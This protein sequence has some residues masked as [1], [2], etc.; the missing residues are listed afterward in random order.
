MRL[1]RLF[2]RDLAKECSEWVKDNL[3]S[4]DQAEKICNRY[5]VNYKDVSGQTYGYSVLIGL[6]YLFIGLAVITLLSANWDDI[7]RAA[8]MLGILSL[9][10][11]INLLAL[12]KIN[13]GKS[14][15]AIGLFFLGGLIYGA[16]IML[17]A[18]IFHIEEH[19]PNG[20]LWWAIGVLPLALL[21][22]SSLLFSLTMGLSFIW[23]FVE[24]NLNY[25]PI[26]F[27]VFL[28]ALGWH[29]FKIKQ[30][31]VLFLSFIFGIGLWLE[32]TM[33]WFLNGGNG[34]YV[35]AEN[36]IFGIGLFISFHGASKWLVSQKNNIL[37]DYGTILGIWILRL[38]IILLLLLSFE[39]LWK[40][41][42]QANWESLELT[43]ALAIS[44]ST[45]GIYLSYA[46]NKQFYSTLFFALIFILETFLVIE[47]KD[48]FYA[49]YFQ[50]ATNIVLVVT[51]IW[52]IV[53][54][55]KDRA[56]H[57]FFLGVSTILLTGFF[58][59]M[60]LVGDYIGA[61]ILFMVFSVILL[62]AARF[63]KSHQQSQGSV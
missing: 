48:D 61:S 38:T 35:G 1:I 2:K 59:Y 51:G 42:I 60:D 6:G 19:Y 22:E 3:I 46:G 21:L 18:Q 12:K 29:V 17:I 25:Y 7:P 13:D 28:G 39:W 53:R 23:F 34:F 56:T 5:D 8:R 4:E 10:T 37:I 50:I 30:S 9:T 26:L 32:F 45:V 16:S 33:A 49:L 55:I 58:R 36:F 15:S 20:I 44:L 62:S 63:W 31:N 27:P 43:M 24:T 14:S 11:L 41:L 52:L 47:I 40:D 54:G 57:Y